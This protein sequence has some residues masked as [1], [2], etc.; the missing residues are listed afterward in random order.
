MKIKIISITTMWLT[1]AL[2]IWL[3]RILWIQMLL[4]GITIAVTIHI[5][6]YKTLK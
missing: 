4:I 3:V 5:L 2:S 1:I 6:S